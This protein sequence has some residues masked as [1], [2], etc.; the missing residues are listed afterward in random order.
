MLIPDSTREARVSHFRELE[1]SLFAWNQT[2]APNIPSSDTN[3][4]RPAVHLALFF[5]IAFIYLGQH[6]LVDLARRY[7]RNTQVEST[8]GTTKVSQEMST[9]CVNAAV[10]IIDLIESLRLGG[11]LA[12]FSIV[13]IH[14]CSSAAMVLIL[15]SVTCPSPET[16]HKIE[17]ALRCLTYIATGS[18]SARN[19]LR[20]IE[21]FQSL[22]D[23]TAARY[24]PE[25]YL[26]ADSSHSSRNDHA[27]AASASITGFQDD[28][29]PS[30]VRGMNREEFDTIQNY[31]LQESTS[32]GLGSDSGGA[33]Q[34]P[35]DYDFPGSDFLQSI[36]Q[37]SFE[38][39][40]IYG[41]SGITSEMDYEI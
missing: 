9:A 38:D 29:D 14:S 24:C 41:F 2:C 1:A 20:L 34:T 33:P 35:F 32:E 36:E 19:G 30:S 4:F 12:L 25:K 28:S 26:Q 11:R 31:G 6:E 8:S 5:N 23:R 10:R 27:G 3:G 16:R 37:Y 7:V 39:L 18:R 13:D 15:S 17:I 21:R 40:A 22:I